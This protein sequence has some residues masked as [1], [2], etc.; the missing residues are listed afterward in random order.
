MFTKDYYTSI[1]IN[2]DA[3][4]RKS[5]KSFTIDYLKKKMDEKTK[6][7]FNFVLTLNNNKQKGRTKQHDKREKRKCKVCTKEWQQKD[8]MNVTSL[9]VVMM[10]KKS[11]ENVMKFI[12]LEN[13]H[14]NQNSNFVQIL[15]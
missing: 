14:E 2:H 9:F 5:G 15:N 11:V 3:F 4:L 6:W 12:L 13:H 10:W 1:K 8:A 7:N